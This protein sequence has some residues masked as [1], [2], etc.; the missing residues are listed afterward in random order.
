M[1]SLQTRLRRADDLTFA[2]LQ[3]LEQQA[4]LTDHRAR[5]YVPVLK[6]LLDAG[7][8][9][10]RQRRALRLIAGW[11]RKHE[12]KGVE[13]EGNRT[14]G[15]AATIFNEVVLAIRAELFSGLPKVL[16]ERQEGVGS[17]V[18]DMS[19]ADNLALRV[20]DPSHSDLPVLGDYTDGRTTRQ[21]VRAALNTA[22]D[23]LEERFGS[24]DLADYRRQHPRA[25]VCSLTGGIIGPCITMPY[26]DRGSYIHVVDFGSR[27]GAGGNDP[28]GD[29]PGGD[30]G[31]E[32]DDRSPS[33]PATG[34]R[35]AA[36]IGLIALA[37]GLWLWRRR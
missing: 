21:V 37:L 9:T 36:I 29:G 15:P 8:L 35:I 31:D 22:L 13:T 16:V 11:D 2:G 6:E 26:Q 19:A 33:L 3:Q 20:L 30:V 24:T 28:D 17:H 14:D 25:D 4:G 7:G 32:D 27:A 10:D 34:T 5:E 18:Y 23:R 1:T 12:G